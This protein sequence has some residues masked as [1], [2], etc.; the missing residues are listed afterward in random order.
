MRKFK[1]VF[2]DEARNF[3]LSLPEQPKSKIVYNIRKVEGGFIS[4]DLFKKLDGSDIW[5]FRTLYNGIQYRLFAFWDTEEGTLV[6]ATHG[7]IKKVWKVPSKEIAKAEE[8][9][10]RYFETK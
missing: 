6:V 7:I 1:T 4:N 2:L 8:I 3:I 5:E 9:R 10:K